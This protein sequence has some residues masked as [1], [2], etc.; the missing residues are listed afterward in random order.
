MYKRQDII[1]QEAIAEVLSDTDALIESLEAK[2]KKKKAIKKGAMQKLLQPQPHWESFKVMEL[3]SVGRGRVISHKEISFSNKKIYPVYSSQ[4]EN[5]G[6]MGYLDSYDFSGEYITW[7]TDGENA[8]TIFHR[9]GKFNCTNV[10]GTIKVHNQC[11]S[12]ISYFLSTISK[13]YVSKNLANPKLMN[14]D[15][16]NIIITFPP[17]CE[18]EDI[19]KILSDMDEELELLEDK[20]NKYRSLKEGLMQELLTLSLIH[21]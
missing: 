15:M 5:N 1:E 9:I 8:G 18:Q 21:I 19:A 7:T 3:S 17:L 16:K 20:L 10:C 6:I 4:T 11:T 2:I 12:F 14:N 13:K